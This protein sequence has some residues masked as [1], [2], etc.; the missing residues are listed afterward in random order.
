VARRSPPILNAATPKATLADLAIGERE[1]EEGI[2]ALHHSLAALRAR[3]QAVEEGTG[4]SQGDAV[5]A[6]E[7]APPRM[8]A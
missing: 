5:R 2:A 8:T 3:R 1:L 7:V 6:Q 4:E